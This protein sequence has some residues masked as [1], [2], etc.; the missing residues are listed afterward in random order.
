[1]VSTSVEHEKLPPIKGVVRASLIIGGWIFTPLSDNQCN[2][3]YILCQDMK[4]K[5]PEFIKNWMA[6]AFSG[7]VQYISEFFDKKKKKKQNKGHN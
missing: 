3:V 1:M 2:A 6:K 7:V 5:I 4:G